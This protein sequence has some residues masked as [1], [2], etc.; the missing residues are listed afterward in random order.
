MANMFCDLNLEQEEDNF[1]E[2]RASEIAEI[3]ESRKI[4][5]EVAAQIWQDEYDASK[6]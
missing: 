5:L 4:S 1:E 2:A 3:S 6:G